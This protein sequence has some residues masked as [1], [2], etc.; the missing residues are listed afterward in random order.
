MTPTTRSPAGVR[1]A[2]AVGRDEG[3]TAAQL[4]AGTGLTEAQVV[5]ADHAIDQDAEFILTANLLR[6]VGDPVSCGIAV[7]SRVTAGDLGIWGYA[8]I[9]SATGAE[10]LAVAVDYVSLA[11]TAFVPEFGPDAERAGESTAVVL[12]DAHLPVDL[13]DF[14][15][16]R[17]ITALPLLLRMAGLGDPALTVHTRFEGAP[18]QR[19]AAAVQPIAVRT[20]AA[21]HR[22]SFARE[23]LTAK[24]PTAD[25]V[26]RM[27]CARE[28]ERLVQIREPTLTATVRSRFAQTPDAMPAIDDLAIELH[29]STRT[30]RRQLAAEGTSYRELRNDV[31]KALAIELLEVVG[32]SV[33][34][35]ARRLGYS[36]AAAFSHAFRRWT[37][38]P[39]GDVRRGI[40][41]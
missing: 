20:G 8:L 37:G 30:L 6:A 17:D 15:A 36:D 25:P 11:P 28:C 9:S 31:G 13:R 40:S 19:L 12:R 14:Y 38:R 22:I 35:V 23:S 33:T 18:G 24:L 39:A 1:Y 10:A 29:M 41:T 2:L 21:Q 3:L 4:L 32:L 5:L 16:A 27:A 34:E 26:T 7:G